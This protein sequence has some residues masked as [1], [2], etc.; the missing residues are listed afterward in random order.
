MILNKYFKKSFIYTDSTERLIA[1]KFHESLL[2][3]I[4]VSPTTFSLPVIQKNQ[5][6]ENRENTFSSCLDMSKGV[7]IDNLAGQKSAK[8]KDR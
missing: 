6:W 8:I 2:D 1:G 5:K 3:I 4:R 7:T